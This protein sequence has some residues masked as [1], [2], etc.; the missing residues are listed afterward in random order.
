MCA[1][2]AVRNPQILID[3][4]LP[5]IPW[6]YQPALSN[7]CGPRNLGEIMI[8]PANSIEKLMLLEITGRKMAS[9]AEEVPLILEGIVMKLE[10]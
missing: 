2:T 3:D 7:L 4:L 1:R 6:E 9:G 10:L 5:G 8:F